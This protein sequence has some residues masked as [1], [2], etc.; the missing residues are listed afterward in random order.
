MYH[1]V[2]KRSGVHSFKISLSEIFYLSIPVVVFTISALYWGNILWLKYDSL[3]DYVFDSGVFLDALYQIFYFHSTS[4]LISYL[5]SSPDKIILSPLSYFHSILFLLY[6]QLIAVLGSTFIIY[7]TVKLLTKSSLF[8]SVMSVLYLLYFPIDGPLFFDVHAQTFFI[9]FLL[10]GFMFQVMNRKYL[11]ILFLL[12]A[13][14]TRFPLIGIVV[15]YSLLDFLRNYR[16]NRKSSNLSEFKHK[17][18]FDMLLFGISFAVL[19]FEYLIEHDF[20]GVQ[21]VSSGYL[22]VQSSGILSNLSSKVITIFFFTAPFLFLVLYVNEFS[23]I[24]WGLFGFISYANYNYYYYP[25]IFTDQYSAIF[26]GVIFLILMVYVSENYR[27]TDNQASGNHFIKE[28]SRFRKTSLAKI[29]VAITL[30]AIILQP[31]SPIASDMGNSFNI[32]SYIEYGSENTS[33]VMKIAGLIPANASGVIIQSD[34]PQI[35]EYDYH[36]NP[37]LVGDVNG[38]PLNYTAKFFDNSSWIDYI[39]GYLG[40]QSFSSV[41]TGLSQ[42]SIM[43]NALSSGKYG[44]LGQIGNLI[45]L[46]RSYTGPPKL[47]IDA[48]HL[49][50][51]QSK[52]YS[53]QNPQDKAILNN[54]ST[55]LDY[56]GSFVLFPGTYAL[57]FS[58]DPLSKVSS[59]YLEIQM[60]GHLFGKD[61]LNIT[62]SINSKSA[63]FSIKFDSSNI[64]LQQYLTISSLNIT[65][66]VEVNS[67]SLTQIS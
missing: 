22:H 11:S 46:K 9:P 44:V 17:A 66:S 49:V 30:F 51:P 48:E 38:Y 56:L 64:Y 4:T 28:I 27:N 36:V 23:V 33:D 37:N 50:I 6:F 32:H 15:L 16:L 67:I 1:D 21:V 52:I 61:T 14:M 19:L 35:L 2:R 34:L 29:L 43:K 63:N 65:G 41:G 26:A 31:M 10:L 24:L 62:K 13:G 40:S 59:A 8:S 45:L 5:G 57:N 18:N 60:Y 39:F 47:F 3:H 42:Y 20:Y 58:L 53:I 12:L 55:S 54:N 25:Q 7:F